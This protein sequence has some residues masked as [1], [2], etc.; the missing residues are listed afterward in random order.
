MPLK[1][2]I[3]GGIGSGKSTICK[4]F[5][6]LNVPVFGADVHAKRLINSNPKVKESLINLFGDGIYKSDGA[7]DRKKLANI[8]FN[9]DLQLAKINAIIH[10]IVRNEF[11]SWF[12]KQNS[13]YVIHEAAILFESGF[14][15][16]M[17]YTILV[18]A[19]IKKRI[20]WLSKRDG[21]DEGL[22]KQRMTKQ[23]SDAQKRKLATI[24]IKNNNIDLIIPQVININ[25][26]IKEYGKI[27]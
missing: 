6:I 24:E 27:W 23:W 4:V 12:E 11:T 14:Y 3:T 15:K 7:I 8:I 19:P 1:I 22:I 10:P 5:E 16:M 2:G 17:D 20:E 18:S 21:I 25:K 9:D 13:T 26:Q